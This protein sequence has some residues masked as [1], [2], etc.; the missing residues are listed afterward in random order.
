MYGMSHSTVVG[1]GLRVIEGPAT[2]LRV[3]RKMK[4]LTARGVEAKASFITYNASGKQLWTHFSTAPLLSPNGMIDSCIA[5]AISYDTLDLNEAMAATEGHLLVVAVQGYKH[6]THATRDLCEL[7]SCGNAKMAGVA[8]KRMLESTINSEV[9]Q[10]L[11]AEIVHGE[12]PRASTHL[13]TLQGSQGN[14]V[15]SCS[16]FLLFTPVK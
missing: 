3:V 8:C 16:P 11:V 10:R 15:S 14:V 1:R 9:L 6:I 12:S 13:M 4:E 5:H 7:L 2:D